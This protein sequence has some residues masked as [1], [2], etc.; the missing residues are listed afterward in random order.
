MATTNFGNAPT[1]P[2]KQTSTL[3]NA[4]LIEFLETHRATVT[5]YV[6]I[7]GNYVEYIVTPVKI[8]LLLAQRQVFLGVEC[9]YEVLDY[10]YREELYIVE[11]NKV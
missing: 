4:Q 11:M 3:S 6:R 5:L 9:T 7:A 1:E 8:F 2:I 10:P